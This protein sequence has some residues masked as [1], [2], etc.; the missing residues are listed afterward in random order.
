MSVCQILW[1]TAVRRRPLLYYSPG[2]SA[3]HVSLLL[4]HRGTAPST[5][6]CWVQPLFTGSGLF[7][8]RE[9]KRTSLQSKTDENQPLTAAQKVKRAGAD[10]TYLIVALIGAGITGGLL[11]VVFTEL[12]S[13]S[14][15]SKIYGNAFEK[16]RIHPEVIGAFGEPIKAFGETTKRGR[17]QHVAS[18]EYFRDGVKC[19]RLKF[20]ISGSEPRIQGVVHVDLKENPESKKY[21][22]QY[23]IVELDTIP[24]RSIVVEDNRYMN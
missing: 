16:C 11:Y 3:A 14:S 6:S 12:F 21:E 9:Q 7:Q 1:R 22:F 20:Y 8:V 24:R 18:T 23:I 17:R 5:G 4:P 15:P 13:S 19:M 2:Y 10:F